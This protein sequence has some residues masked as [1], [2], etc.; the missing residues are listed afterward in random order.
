MPSEPA[1]RRAESPGRRDERRLLGVHD[2]RVE[3]H[4]VGDRAFPEHTAIAEAEQSCAPA[5]DELHRPFEGHQLTAPQAVGEELR[6]V[7]QPT[8]AVE[9]RARVGSA[10]K[11]RGSFQTCR[12]SSPDAP[13]SSFGTGHSTV[14]RSSAITMSRSVPKFDLPA[15]PRFTDQ[16]PRNGSFSSE[17][18]SP[19][20]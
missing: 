10:D 18:T 7:G 12:R 15:P 2:R 11:A 17:Y 6:G 20:G 13:S 16:R 5:R 8:H 4:D 3:H 1:V 19:S 14:R 9:V